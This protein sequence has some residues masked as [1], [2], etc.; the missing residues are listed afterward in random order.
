MKVLLTQLGHGPKGRSVKAGL[1][2]GLFLSVLALAQFE[3]LHQ[4]VH[5]DADQATHECAVTLLVS[6]K[7]CVT[8]GNVSTVV[9]SLLPP[10][11]IQLITAPS[12][13]PSTL[14]PS[15]RAPPATCS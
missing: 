15:G 12:G 8:D 3:T 13:A 4:A 7:A 6:G 11:E 14:L 9:T 10:V 1:L 5:A 2:L